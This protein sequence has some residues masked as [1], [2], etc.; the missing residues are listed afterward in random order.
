MIAVLEVAQAE[1]GQKFTP[2]KP[3][4]IEMIPDAISTKI[5]GMK[6]GVKRGVPSP[7]QYSIIWSW[8]VW[9]PPFPEPQITP[10]RSLLSCSKSI[11][12]SFTALST[13]TRAYCENGSYL[14]I[15]FTSKCAFGSK[16]FSSQSKVVLNLEVSN[17]VM[18]AAPLLPATILL[19][20]V[21]T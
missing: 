19:Q 10:M 11:L 8:N 5:L 12:P 4:L 6:N 3:Y 1:T 13:A 15:S 7:S 14:R 2:R 21:S 9:I 17:L 16:P 20:K 18:A